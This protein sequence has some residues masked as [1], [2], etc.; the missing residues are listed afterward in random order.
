MPKEWYIKYTFEKVE[1]VFEP[2]LGCFRDFLFSGYLVSFPTWVWH[3]EG[4]LLLVPL[5]PF[6]LFSPP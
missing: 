2:A 1:L 3:L 4:A 6:Q 5:A